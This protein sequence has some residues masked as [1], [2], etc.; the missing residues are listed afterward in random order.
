MD[1]Y[2]YTKLNNQEVRLLELQP[3]RFDDELWAA[4]YPITLVEPIAP[5]EQLEKRLSLQDLKATLPPGWTAYETVEGRYIFEHPETDITSWSHPDV[6]IPE[7]DYTLSVDTSPHSSSKPKY[8]ALS[9]TWGTAGQPTPLH[10]KP[11]DPGHPTLKIDIQQNLAAALRHLRLPDKPRAL[12]VD[13]VC[14]NQNDTAERNAQVPRMTGIYKRAHSVVAWLGAS[15]SDS[16]LAMATLEAIGTQIELGKCATRLKPPGTAFP[17]WFHS[18]GAL[19]F[20]EDA[21]RAIHDLVSRPWFDRVW[22]VQEL[23]LANPTATLQ[24]GSDSLNWLHFCRAAWCLFRKRAPPYPPLARRLAQIKMLTRPALEAIAFRHL[25][26]GSSSRRCTDPRDHVYGMLGLASP[27]ISSLI[28]PQYASDVSA[29]FVDAL[30]AILQTSNRLD[31]LED[32]A[33]RPGIARPSQ[34]PSWVPN[35][36]VPIEEQAGVINSLYSGSST[37]GAQATFHAPDMLEVCGV[38]CDRISCVRGPVSKDNNDALS[39]IRSWAPQNIEVQPYP[40]GDR[41]LTAFALALSLGMVRDRLP[42]AGD[43]LP[44]VKELE[45]EL[46][47]FLKLPALNPDMTPPVAFRQMLGNLTG[48]VFIETKAGY[49]GLAPAETKPGM[50]AVQPLHPSI[51]FPSARALT[52][53][54]GPHICHSGLS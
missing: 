21:W 4:V 43:L 26:Y 39:S 52:P 5:I 44:T 17:E 42:L 6:T 40:T 7:S 51:A 9:Y 19:P 33:L 34:L 25:L 47:S 16:Q 3:G 24:C 27:S 36:T 37:S 41:G 13:A 10:I 18:S 38:L 2:Q 31:T 12:W 22:V 49:F 32:C 8:E 46:E 15:S 48:R 14:I 45:A 28:K 30:L 53:L 20:D 35:W 50:T 11:S 54:R 1:A 29:V 23:Q